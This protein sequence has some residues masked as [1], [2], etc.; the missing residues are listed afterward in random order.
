WIA[1]QTTAL[2]TLIDEQIGN[3]AGAAREEVEKLVKALDVLKETR[4]AARLNSPI[5]PAATA[6]TIATGSLPSKAGGGIV[7]GPPG[8]PVPILAHGGEA[9]GGIPGASPGIPVHTEGHMGFHKRG[10]RHNGRPMDRNI[11]G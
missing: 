4:Q 3:A 7:P 2:H 10:S 1:E 9:V 8:Q 11:R 6:T 5:A